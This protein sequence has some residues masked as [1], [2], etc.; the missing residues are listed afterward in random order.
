MISIR[1]TLSLED[2]LTDFMC[3]PAELDDWLFAQ[4][5]SG[6]ESWNASNTAGAA[7]ALGRSSEAQSPP[8]LSPPA[9]P[10]ARPSTHGHSPSASSGWPTP[11]AWPEKPSSEARTATNGSDR[12]S[13]SRTL[14][15]LGPGLGKKKEIGS[16]AVREGGAAA[17]TLLRN[18][19]RSPAD[20]RAVSP[21]AHSSGGKPGSLGIH[22]GSAHGPGSGTFGSGACGY[23]KP[24]EAAGKEGLHATDLKSYGGDSNLANCPDTFSKSP[25]QVQV[26]IL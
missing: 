12:R 20:G 11:H 1:G 17:G 18:R 21:V 6:G 22:A 8:N 16:A 2:C 10:A 4:H 25:P 14:E 5:L 23:P 3:E 19:S 15:D 13:A 7:I 24:S 9:D 26:S